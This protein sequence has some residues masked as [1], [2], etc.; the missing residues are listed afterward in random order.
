[1][2]LTGTFHIKFQADDR[3]NVGSKV[4]HVHSDT[5]AIFEHSAR[6]TI[7]LQRIRSSGG[8]VPAQRAKHTMALHK[9]Q[10]SRDSAGSSIHS[11][12]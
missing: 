2:G 12:G 4:L 6:Q 1:M 5:A 10:L 9:R 3:P 11:S 8:G 7:T